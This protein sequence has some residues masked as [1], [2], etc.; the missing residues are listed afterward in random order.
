M[1]NLLTTELAQ[2][3]VKVHVCNVTVSLVVK[4]SDI[5]KDY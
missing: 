2:R 4:L 1:I 5:D 3:V